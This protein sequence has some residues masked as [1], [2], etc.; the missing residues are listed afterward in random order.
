[1][2]HCFENW[3]FFLSLDGREGRKEFYV[4]GP[5][6]NTC[7]TLSARNCHISIS[8]GKHLLF[9][10]DSLQAFPHMADKTIYLITFIVFALFFKHAWWFLFLYK[11]FLSCTVL[12]IYST[13]RHSL[14]V[15]CFSLKLTHLEDLSE[16][17]LEEN[18]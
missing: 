1:M 18:L 13:F 15:D 4:G 3:L 7:T 10:C 8:W 14:L 12:K 2:P 6:W 9:L 5:I 16:Y 11:D 17:A